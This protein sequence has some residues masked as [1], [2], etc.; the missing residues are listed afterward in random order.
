MYVFHGMNL[1]FK[2]TLTEAIFFKEYWRIQIKAVY[3]YWNQLPMV[4]MCID[5]VGRM[6]V[7]KLYEFDA[8][9]GKHKAFTLKFL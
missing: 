2:T 3:I 5:L 1:F 8:K 6:Q 7:N 9:K 4:L